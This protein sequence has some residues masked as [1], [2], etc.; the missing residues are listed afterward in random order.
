MFVLFFFIFC[1]CKEIL[2]LNTKELLDQLIQ[3]QQWESD[4]PCNKSMA[5]LASVSFSELKWTEIDE[6]CFCLFHLL[7]EDVPRNQC[8]FLIQSQRGA[9]FSNILVEERQKII[10]CI[11]DKILG[12]ALH[13]YIPSIPK[14]IFENKFTKYK[15]I[16]YI[17]PIIA[18]YAAD[19]MMTDQ[20]KQ[21][22]SYKDV[23]IY[24]NLN[25]SHYEEDDAVHRDMLI[26]L[27]SNNMVELLPGDMQYTEEALDLIYRIHF[28]LFKE[29]L[30]ELINLM[31]K[32]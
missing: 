30:I 27:K 18:Q 17:M 4:S 21:T 22:Q 25:I 13:G 32:E 26:Y 1:S 16:M 8:D 2:N 12:R 19:H 20:V 24:F 5:Q 31:N 11:S 10:H 14:D 15:Y 9:N 28:V 23:W 29:T 7:E 3:I 6:A